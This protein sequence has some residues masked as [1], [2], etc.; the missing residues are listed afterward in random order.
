MAPEARAN[1]DTTRFHRIFS[2]TVLERLD[3]R[4]D[5]R[6]LYL[7][8]VPSA[9]RSAAYNVVLII[10]DKLRPFQCAT[11]HN[12]IDLSFLRSSDIQ[13]MFLGYVQGK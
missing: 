8:A 9:L 5:Y 12:A 4:R 11:V 7:T 1:W 6:R 10:F 2:T 3:E 13:D